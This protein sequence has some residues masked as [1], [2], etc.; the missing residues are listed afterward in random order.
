MI[1]DDE[2]PVAIAGIMGGKNSSV[3]DNTTDILLEGASF[4]SGIVRRASKLLGLRTDASARF[5]RGTD[6]S[7]INDTVTYAAH[8]IASISGGTV[9]KE[10]VDEWIT[11]N[12][13]RKITF[14]IQQVNRILGTTISLNEIKEILHRLEI[15]IIDENEAELTLSPPSYRNDITGEIDL[16]EEIARIYGYNNIDSK[17]AKIVTSSLPT[18]P[19]VIIEKTCREELCKA[20]LQEFITC[21]LISPKQA[22]FVSTDEFLL[23][24]LKPSS[25]DQS[26]LRPSMLPGLLEVIRHNA[27]FGTFDIAGFEIGRVHYKEREATVERPVAAIIM[28]GKKTP[29][30]WDQTS[31]D[32]LD[33]YDVKGTLES[34][35]K[36][37]SI[38]DATYTRSSTKHLP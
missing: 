36:H 32:K 2:K 37:F 9:D 21:D 28:T 14:R 16:I 31:D 23:H 10:I 20:G 13:R 17:T 33:F 29:H 18:D 26:I 1:Y 3:R 8:L 12:V 24:V 7:Q 4:E 11:P 35:I 25:V 34:V 19:R 30:C 38:S 22:N 6:L 5:E 15:V 27:A